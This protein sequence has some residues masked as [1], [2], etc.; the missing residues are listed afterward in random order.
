MSRRSTLTKQRPLPA[1]WQIPDPL[2]ERIAP[3]LAE[4][5]PPKPTGRPRID[6]RRALDAVVYHLRTGCQW[7][8]LPAEFPDDSSVHRTYQRWIARQVF[9]RIWADLIEVCEDLNGVDW[10]WQAADGSLGKAR[11]GGAKSVRTPPIGPRTA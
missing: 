6:A 8:H 10:A 11:K 5:D 1:I 9:D 7:N 3:V 2:W 4:L